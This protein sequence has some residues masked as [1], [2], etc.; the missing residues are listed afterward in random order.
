MSDEEQSQQIDPSKLIG[1]RRAMT[2]S[3]RRDRQNHIYRRGEEVKVG[4]GMVQGLLMLHSLNSRMWL[5]RRR[6]ST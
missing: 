6:W 4:G 1:G 5:T 3:V 2:Q